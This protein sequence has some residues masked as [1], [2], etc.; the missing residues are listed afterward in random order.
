M[1]TWNHVAHGNYLIYGHIHNNTDGIYWPLLAQMDQAL[2]AG[3]DI[4]G[5]AP[6]DVC[7]TGGK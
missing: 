4:N 5:F 1:M 2:N 6:V 7:G 3:A